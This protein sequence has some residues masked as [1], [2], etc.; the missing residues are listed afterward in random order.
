[1]PI[2]IRQYILWNIIKAIVC[3][4]AHTALA[5]KFVEYTTSWAWN[6]NTIKHSHQILL[7]KMWKTNRSSVR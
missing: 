4:I 7:V 5:L 6:P 2:D 3:K 1:M